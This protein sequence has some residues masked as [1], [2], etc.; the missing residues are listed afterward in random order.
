[1]FYVVH[2]SGKAAASEG[3]ILETG[4]IIKK[5]T[6]RTQQPQQRKASQVYLA[7]VETAA[8]VRLQ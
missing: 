1:M 2:G 8:L 7:Q 3:H 6:S 5:K 4:I